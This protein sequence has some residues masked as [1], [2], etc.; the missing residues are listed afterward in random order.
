MTFRRDGTVNTSRA[1]STLSSSEGAAAIFTATFF[2]A[3]LMPFFGKQDH[4][5]LPLANT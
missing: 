4:H 1:V 5:G 3:A 2:G